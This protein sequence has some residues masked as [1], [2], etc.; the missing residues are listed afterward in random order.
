MVNL[1][2][3]PQRLKHNKHC[4]WDFKF[5]SCKYR[6]FVTVAVT[7]AMRHCYHRQLSDF[8]FF[9]CSREEWRR[10]AELL[11]E[12]HW[13]HLALMLQSCEKKI[14]S[15]S[16]LWA[17]FHSETTFQKRPP[18]DWMSC[19]AWLC[20]HTKDNTQ[21]HNCIQCET[22]EGT[23]SCERILHRKW[24]YVFP[25]KCFYRIHP[26]FCDTTRPHTAAYSRHS[27]IA[28]MASATATNS[29]QPHAAQCT[30]LLSA[31]QCCSVR[32][33]AEPGQCRFV[34]VWWF[35]D[36]NMLS[37]VSP[38]TSRSD[39]CDWEEPSRNMSLW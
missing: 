26:G 15:W 36:W 2:D 6:G 28:C 35:R 34:S 38:V 9:D 37:Q 8:Q 25:S 1:R 17:K 21:C 11:L 31:A 22:E 32:A 16:W 19:C 30:V 4:C 13:R 39:F 14:W 24:W 10:D 27:R 5:V 33:N 7:L 3:A 23:A 20:G 12:S 18:K 29:W